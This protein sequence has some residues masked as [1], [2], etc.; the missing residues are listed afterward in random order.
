MG[1]YYDRRGNEIPMLVWARLFDGGDRRVAFS[2]VE[3]AEVS[4]VWLGLNHQWQPGGAPLIFE[5]MIF[6]GKHDGYCRR[7]STQD[8]AEIGHALILSRLLQEKHPDGE[9]R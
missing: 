9:E 3:D 5:T 1:S 8:A 6:G 2:K 7:Y 4:T